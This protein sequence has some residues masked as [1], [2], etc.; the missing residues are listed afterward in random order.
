MRLNYL[1]IYKAWDDKQWNWHVYNYVSIY[2]TI[3][4][5]V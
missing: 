1:L 4:N 5:P 2:Y 3:K